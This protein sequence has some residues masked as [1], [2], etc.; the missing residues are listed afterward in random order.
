MNRSGVFACLVLAMLILMDK[1]DA[2]C[3]RYCFGKLC[4]S[5][6]G[7]GNRTE[8]ENNAG[9]SSHVKKRALDDANG[10]LLMEESE[11]DEQSV[12]FF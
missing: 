5:Y 7:R 11:L 6:C 8:D 12:V 3:R 9:V 10:T 1:T 4:L 2:Q